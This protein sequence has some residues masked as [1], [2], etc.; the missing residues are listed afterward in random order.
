LARHGAGG[1]WHADFAAALPSA[2]TAYLQDHQVRRR[3]P[4]NHR[5]ADA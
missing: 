1:G 5:F 2:A 3:Q 4:A